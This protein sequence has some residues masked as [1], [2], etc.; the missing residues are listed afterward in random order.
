MQQAVLTQPHIFEMQQVPIP[1]IS[2]NQ[3]LIRVHRVGICGTDVHIFKGHYASES[4]PLTMGHEFSGEVVK[5]GNTVRNVEIGDRVTADIN[6]SCGHC[7]YCRKN[8]LLNCPEMSQ[9][10]ISENGAFCEY[11]ATNK[12]KVIKAPK[13][14]PYEIL[15]LVEPLACVVRSVRKS[16]I[17][18]AQSA[19]VIGAGPIGNLHIQVLRSIG[20]APIIV[21]ELSEVRAEMALQ[22]GAD[23]VVTAPENIEEIVQNATDGRG[24]DVVIESVGNAD[25]YADAF[26]YIRPGG[27]IVAFG[28]TQPE[29]TFSVKSLDVVLQEL[30]IKGSVAGMGDDMYEALTLLAHNRI[31]T[32]FFTKKTVTLD[33]IQ[34]AFDTISDDETVFKVQIQIP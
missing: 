12:Q 19:L 4:L 28:L 13:D 6:T 29:A 20:V 31:K 33:K 30:S 23:I 15:C 26:C 11:I 27:H 2:E 18:F 16:K 10:G 24:V 17:T 14:M 32:D 25:L 7:F 3:V 8:E 5:I 1:E 22:S 34:H 9:L 21:L